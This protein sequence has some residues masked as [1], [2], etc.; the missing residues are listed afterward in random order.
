MSLTFTFWRLADLLV[1]ILPAWARGAAEGD[2]TDGFGDPSHIDLAHPLSRL[3]ML[4]FRLCIERSWVC[5]SF[6]RGETMLRSDLLKTWFDRDP[7]Q[8][9]GISL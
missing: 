4:F 1:D 2:I 6:A 7:S 3:S 5:Q 9:V 8:H